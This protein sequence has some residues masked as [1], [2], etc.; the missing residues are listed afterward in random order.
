MEEDVGKGKIMEVSEKKEK[1]KKLM[2]LVWGYLPGASPQRSSILHPMA[3]P[4]P[5]SSTSGDS[6]RDVCGGGCGFAMAISGISPALSISFCLAVSVSI[7]S[8][9]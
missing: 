8:F 2:V 1:K 3:V 5:G 4:L 6:W 7:D 9:A